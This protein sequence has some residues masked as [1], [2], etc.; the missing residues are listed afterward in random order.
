MDFILG[1]H[2]K[3]SF[4]ISSGTTNGMVLI[5]PKIKMKDVTTTT[6]I[7]IIIIQ[8]VENRTACDLYDLSSYSLPSKPKN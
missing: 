4:V 2:R 7:I 1:I 3:S 5:N 8:N 6:I